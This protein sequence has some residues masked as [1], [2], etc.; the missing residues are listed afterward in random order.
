MATKMCAYDSGLRRD[1]GIRNELRA[2]IAAMMATKIRESDSPA[3]IT[4]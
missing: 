3:G 2:L 1:D 4:T